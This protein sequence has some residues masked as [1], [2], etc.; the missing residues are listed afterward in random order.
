MWPE[1]SVFLERNSRTFKSRSA[2]VN[3][4]TEALCD[5]LKDHPKGKHES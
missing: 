4:N 5:Y 3:A 2:I 1:M